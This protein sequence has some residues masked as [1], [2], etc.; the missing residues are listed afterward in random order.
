MHAQENAWSCWDFAG[1][2]R[3]VGCHLAGVWGPYLMVASVPILHSNRNLETC[4]I[5]ISN[6]TKNINYTL[7][8]DT[9]GLQKSTECFLLIFGALIM[10]CKF[11]A[12]Y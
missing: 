4:F 12:A 3:E 9:V 11:G 2:C 7:N 6:N 10:Y 1:C 5:P 8:T